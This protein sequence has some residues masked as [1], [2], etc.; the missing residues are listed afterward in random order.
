[1]TT[2]ST[3]VTPEEI[4]Q[5]R[6]QFSDY[7]ESLDALDLIEECNGDLKQ[8]ANLLVLESGIVIPKK[9]PDTLDEL[10][11]KCRNIVCD[12]VFINELMTGVLTAAVTSLTA[13]GQIPAALATPVVIYL[14]KKGVKKWCE[15][16]NGEPKTL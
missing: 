4:A 13:S 10:A 14:A 7:P 5:Y 11:Q 16:S 15:S 6:E 9:V 12:E 1:M 8:A 3:Q 2:D